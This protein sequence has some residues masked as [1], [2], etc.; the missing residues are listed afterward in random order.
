MT[1]SATKSATAA[2]EKQQNNTI[3]SEYED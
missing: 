3:N 1:K 2:D